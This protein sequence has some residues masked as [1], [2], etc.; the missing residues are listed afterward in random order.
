MSTQKERSEKYA[1]QMNAKG[2]RRAIVW[3]HDD[4]REALIEHA[5]KLKEARQ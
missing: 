5:R 2:F 3:V 4:D 1:K